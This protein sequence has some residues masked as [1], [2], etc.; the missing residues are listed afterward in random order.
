MWTSPAEAGIVAAWP[1]AEGSSGG[2]EIPLHVE[3]QALALP[4]AEPLHSYS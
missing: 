4:V 3:A 1:G 2:K